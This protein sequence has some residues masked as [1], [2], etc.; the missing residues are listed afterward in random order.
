MELTS[1]LKNAESLKKS[2]AKEKPFEGNLLTQIRDY[3]RVGLT[4]ASNAL[5]GNSLTLSETKILIEDGLTVG[6]KPFLD[7]VEAISHARAYD[8]MFEM[9]NKKSISIEDIK[10]LHYLFFSPI[11]EKAAGV[12]RKGPVFIS[13]SKY[14]VCPTWQIEN[15]MKQ[16]DDWMKKN[17]SN[18]NP[19][20]FAADLHANFV[21]IHPFINGNGRVARLVMNLSLLQEGYMMAV[22]SPVL[23]NEYVET[24]EKTRKSNN[25]F[26]SLIAEAVIESEKDMHRSIGIDIPSLIK[27]SHSLLDEENSV[28]RSYN[29][30]MIVYQSPFISHELENEIDF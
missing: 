28:E 8:R 12:W 27:I 30:E 26:R 3:Y 19:I 29:D 24:L 16:L 21:R 10:E 11:N 22:I 23:R 6:G 15:E 2:L 7:S 17:R 13:G 5:E 18:M 14:S 4:Y 9:I 1:L 25:P 20:E